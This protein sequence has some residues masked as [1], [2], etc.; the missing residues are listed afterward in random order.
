MR[1]DLVSRLD[2]PTSGVLPLATSQVAAQLLRCQFTASLVKKENLR[3][4]FLFG[5]FGWREQCSHDGKR[6]WGYCS[7]TNVH[8][9]YGILSYLIGKDS[10]PK[11][12]IYLFPLSMI[13]YN[14]FLMCLLVMSV[15][16]WLFGSCRMLL[17]I[18]RKTAPTRCTEWI[19][20]VDEISSEC[21]Q[22]IW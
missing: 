6:I 5:L 9:W 21:I 18:R 11:S 19:I 20:I 16:I 10:S 14:S 3:L 13:A 7:L 8:H 4:R 1:L 12:C 17:C 15:S 22:T 2:L